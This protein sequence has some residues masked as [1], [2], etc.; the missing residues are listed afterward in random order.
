MLK[1]GKIGDKSL[2]LGVYLTF[3]GVLKLGGIFKMLVNHLVFAS[4]QL[5]FHVYY[6]DYAVTLALRQGVD[7]AFDLFRG[8]FAVR[9]FFMFEKRF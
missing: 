6:R 4:C 2:K 5:R 3:F 8:W 9:G 1:K 7:V